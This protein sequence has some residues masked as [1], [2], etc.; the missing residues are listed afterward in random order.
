MWF[1]KLRN[2]YVIIEHNIINCNV[3]EVK[4]YNPRE[5]WLLKEPRVENL[6]WVFTSNTWNNFTMTVTIHQIKHSS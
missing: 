2:F 3:T 1:Q 4:T 5:Y 6:D